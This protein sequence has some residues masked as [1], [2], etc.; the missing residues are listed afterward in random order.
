DY[1]LAANSPCIDSGTPSG[2]LVPPNFEIIIDDLLGYNYFGYNYDIGCYEWLGVGVSNGEMEII[3]FSLSNYPNPFNPSTTISFS[4]PEESK[5]EIIVYNIKGQ[6]V[7]I[8]AKNVFEKGYHT[9]TW[10]GDDES[11]KTVGSGVYFYKLK[12]GKFTETKKMILIK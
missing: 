1:H 2:W 12:A 4:I 8:V 7:K 6:K 11:G 9:L 3:S 10:Q 5:V